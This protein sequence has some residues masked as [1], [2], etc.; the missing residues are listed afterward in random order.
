MS[1]RTSIGGAG[2]ALIL[3]C[4]LGAATPPAA[5]DDHWKPWGATRAPDQTLRPG[6][7]KYRYHYRVSPPTNSW[8][9]EIFLVNRKG[10][11]VASDA[12]LSESDPAKGWLKWRICRPSTVYG[13]HKIKMK[14]TY[15]PDPGDDTPDVVSGWVKPSYFRLTRP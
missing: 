2:A 13:K 14:V 5:A 6:C 4:G 9:A 1:L 8:M 10:I 7:H 11:G 12:V 15:D 3:M